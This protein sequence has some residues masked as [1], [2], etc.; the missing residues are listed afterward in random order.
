MHADV[1]F[2]C[3]HADIAAPLDRQDITSKDGIV[4][5]AGM[6]AE[7]GE[8]AEITENGVAIVIVATAGKPSRPVSN[9]GLFFWREL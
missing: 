1:V 2:V 6:T 3:H 7:S 9:A 4:V 8:I 5:T